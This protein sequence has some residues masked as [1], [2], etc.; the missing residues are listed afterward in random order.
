MAGKLFAKQALG[1][2]G[3]GDD[4]TARGFLVDPVDDAEVLGFH[5]LLTPEVTQQFGDVAMLTGFERRA[6]HPRCLVDHHH[7][8]VVIEDAEWSR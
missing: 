2:A 4:Q 1:L 8:V 3:Q 5:A 6:Q 7:I